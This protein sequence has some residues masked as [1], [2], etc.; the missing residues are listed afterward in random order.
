M[1]KADR[2]LSTP[3]TNTPISQVDATSRRRFL[4]QA[5]GIAAG[6]TVLALATAAAPAGAAGATIVAVPT[7]AQAAP[8]ADAELLDLEERIFE[9]HAAAKGYN[10]EIERLGAI[11]KS[12]GRRL[13]DEA[14]AA[15]VG[16][17]AT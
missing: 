8:D 5:A 4:T 6:G 14:L 9:H 2:V 15:E 1:A 17:G 12:E 16:Q 11:V 7:I 13:Y 10:I 3:P